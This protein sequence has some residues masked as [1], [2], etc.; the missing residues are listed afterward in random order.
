[1]SPSHTVCLLFPW[2]REMLRSRRHSTGYHFSISSPISMYLFFPLPLCLL[3]IKYRAIL[4]HWQGNSKL[5][6]GHTSF[7]FF[8]QLFDAS[9]YGYFLSFLPPH[10]HPC[11]VHRAEISVQMFVVVDI[12]VLAA[13]CSTLPK[14]NSLGKKKK[15][16]GFLLRAPT[17]GGI[18]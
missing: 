10:L 7:F 11:Q 12:T 14:M 15:S 9:L 16:F 13:F 17:L 18:L 1:M 5:A 8:C 2:Q 3:S 4:L 6:G